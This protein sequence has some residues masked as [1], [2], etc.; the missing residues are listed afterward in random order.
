MAGAGR[1]AL[2]QVFLGIGVH[3]VSEAADHLTD[4]FFVAE[5]QASMRFSRAVE[6]VVRLSSS[7]MTGSV[8]DTFSLFS[9][10]V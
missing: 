7:M 9:T 6:P 1:S 8:A 2:A 4:S 3:L 10:K 5:I